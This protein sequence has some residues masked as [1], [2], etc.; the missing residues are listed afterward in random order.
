MKKHLKL[1]V[2]ALAL[3]GTA[4]ASA[5]NAMPGGKRGGPD[6]EPPSFEELDTNGDGVVTLEELEALGAARFA[7]MDTDGDGSISADEMLAAMQERAAERM[8]KGIERM[9]EKHDENGDG[10]LSAEELPQPKHDRMIERLDEDG[11][12]AISAEEFEAA[13]EKRDERGKHSG[14]NGRGHGGGRG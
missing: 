8:A 11:D 2:L 12:G 4:L 9:I 6:M 14:K 7:E 10:V 13:K 3:T 1:T 5:A